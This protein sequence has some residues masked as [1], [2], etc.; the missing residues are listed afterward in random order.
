[1]GDL[2]ILVGYSSKQMFY[3]QKCLIEVFN[4]TGPGLH[5]YFKMAKKSKSS[6]GGS[7][8]EAYKMVIDYNKVIISLASTILAAQLAFLVLQQT[9]F[10][11]LNYASSLV[12]VLAITLSFF[13]FGRAIQVVKTACSDP[14]AIDFTNA[15]TIVLIVG[16]LLIGLIQPTKEQSIDAMLENIE[17]NTSSLGKLNPENCTQIE[18]NGDHYRLH[19]QSP[20]SDI[21]VVYSI[22]DQRILSITP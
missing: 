18:M 9:D 11:L 21:E 6:K 7:V 20:K 12:L 2:A 14:K 15:S 3:F 10:N 17:S 5:N 13:G 8:V 16:I 4:H 1:L 19:Y 22:Q